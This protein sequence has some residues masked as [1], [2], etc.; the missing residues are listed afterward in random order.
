M[1]SYYSPQE[2]QM[3]LSDYP[4]FRDRLYCRGFLLTNERQNI[5]AEYPFYSN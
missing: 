3:V 5:A 1:M 4:Q 2:M